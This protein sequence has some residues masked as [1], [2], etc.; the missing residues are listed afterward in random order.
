[1]VWSLSLTSDRTHWTSIAP[2]WYEGE[3]DAWTIRKRC[4]IPFLTRPHSR[5]R[6]PGIGF[7]GL[8]G[9]RIRGHL[10]VA[11]ADSSLRSSTPILAL[12]LA[13]TLGAD[14]RGDGRPHRPRRLPVEWRG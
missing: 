7:A 5:A 13:P 11:L 6:G 14:H 2:V 8:L 9:A 4:G 1:M 10:T 12:I 3:D